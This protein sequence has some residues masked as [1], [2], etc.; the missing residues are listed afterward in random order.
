MKDFSQILIVLSKT[1]CARA[2]W[3]YDKNCVIVQILTDLSVGRFNGLVYPHRK[4][5]MLKASFSASK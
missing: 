4:K 5:K 2:Q 3:L 1:Y